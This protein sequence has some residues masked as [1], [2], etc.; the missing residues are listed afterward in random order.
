VRATFCRTDAY[1]IHSGSFHFDGL[2]QNVGTAWDI[3]AMSDQNA[4]FGSCGYSARC[5]APS[6]CFEVVYCNPEAAACLQ[7]LLPR[8]SRETSCI[9]LSDDALLPSVLCQAT[10]CQ[11]CRQQF[12]SS[13]PW[14]FTAFVAAIGCCW[15]ADA[16]KADPNRKCRRLDCLTELTASFTD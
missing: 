1:S 12:Q 3:A 9:F 2:D 16:A 11:L 6:E 8:R 5:Q 10:Q 13:V 15:N 14:S 7:R 4:L